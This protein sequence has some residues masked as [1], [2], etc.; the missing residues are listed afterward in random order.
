VYDQN[1]KLKYSKEVIK[2]TALPIAIRNAVTDKYPG[3]TLISDQETIKEGRSNFIHYRI[4]IE[5]GKEKK[6][7]AVN[8]NGK[9]LREKKV[10]T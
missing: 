1:G 4:I 3:F 9:I 6:A 5:K 7:V 2:D 8:A 10:R